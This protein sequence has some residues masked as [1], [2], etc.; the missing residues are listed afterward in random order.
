MEDNTFRKETD[1]LEKSC[2]SSVNPNDPNTIPKYADP[3]QIPEV[4]RPCGMLN[5]KEYYEIKM[6]PTWHRFHKYFPKTYAWGY[7]GMI[8]GPTIEVLRDQRV[9]VKWVNGLPLKHF[10][11]VDKTLH[12]TIGTPEVRTVVHLHG[13]NVDPDSDG[14]PEAWFTNDYLVVGKTF[15]RE[16]YEYTNHQQATTLWYHDH[17]IGITRLNVYAGLAGFY[18]IRDTLEK[19]LGLPNGKYEIPLIIQDKTFNEDG[20]LFYPDAAP[21]PVPQ[22][23]PPVS[24]SISPFFAGDTIV[25]NGKVWP[26]L[27]VEPKK[28]RFRILNASNT[29]AYNLTLSNGQ[30]FLQIGTDGGMLEAPV[31]LDFI[32]LLPAERTDMVIDFKDYKGQ[33]II[34]Q[35]TNAPEGSHTREIMKFMVDKDAKGE[36][37]SRVPENLYPKGNHLTEDMATKT[38]YLSLVAAP[39]GDDYGRPMLLLDNLMWHDPVTEQPKYDSIE[40]WNLINTTAAP[41]VVLAHPIHVHLV[42]FKILDRRPFDFQLYL[43]TNGKVLKYTGPAEPPRPFETGWKDVVKA[44]PG[45]VT[46]IIMHFKDHAGDFVWHCHFLE[47]EDHDMMR[48]FKVVKDCY[49]VDRKEHDA[50]CIFEEN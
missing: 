37:R 25:V 30:K 34:L 1:E 47:H 6:M 14:H 8:P 21:P 48:P 36:D 40:V 9:Y 44:D 7:N 43:D 45:F 15:K 26:Y 13:A 18:L 17:A 31:E 38:R 27:K 39:N 10:L 50:P 12:G 11:P 20:S 24:P 23:Q 33:E 19:E 35:N 5:G 29:T 3:L 41:P 4:V 28:Y 32:E 42:Q 16:V 49:P 2:Q 46:R 22:P